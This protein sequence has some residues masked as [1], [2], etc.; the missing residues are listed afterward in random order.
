MTFTSGRLPSVSVA[1]M[2]VRDVELSAGQ[3]TMRVFVE[4]DRFNLNYM[5][6]FTRTAQRQHDLPTSTKRRSDGRCRRD[7]ASGRIIPAEPPSANV[8]HK[9]V[10]TAPAEG[11]SASAG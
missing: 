6:C 11:A 4:K 2:I 10:P 1:P 8:P 5:E 9:K 3:H 7:L